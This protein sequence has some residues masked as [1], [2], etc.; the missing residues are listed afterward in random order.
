MKR[1][2]ETFADLLAGAAGIVLGQRGRGCPV[3]VVRG[4]AYERSDSGVASILHR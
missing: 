1:Q 4:V 2:E 3:V